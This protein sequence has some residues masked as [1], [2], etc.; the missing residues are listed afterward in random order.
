MK[1]APRRVLVVDDDAAHRTMLC[2]ILGDLDLAVDRAADGEEALHALASRPPDL[3]ILDMRMPVLDGLGTLR[4]MSERS[5]HVPTIILTAHADLDD[6]VQA[7]KL[8]ALDYLRKPIDIASLQSLL[9]QHLAVGADRG[10]DDLPDLPLGV[11]AQSPLMRAVLADLARVAAS[12]APLLL[13]GETGTG[14]DVLAGLAHRWSRQNAGPLVA[15]NVAALPESLVESELFGHSRG[16]FTGAER[17]RKGH[18][19][20]ADGGTLF[21]DEIGEMPLGVQ[22]KILRA[23]QDGKISRLGEATER[24]FNFR[25]VSAT[26]RDLEGAVAAGEFRQDLYYRIAVITIEVPPLRE[27]REDILPLARGFL[28]RE[29]GGHKR[30]SPSAEDLLLSYAW[31]GNI[32]ELSSAMLRAA[33]LAPGDVILPDNLPPALRSGPTESVGLG[34]ETGPDGSDLSLAQLEKRAIE[35]ALERSGGNR[36]EA[37][38]ALGISRRK[39]LYRLKQYREG[40]AD[41]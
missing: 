41:S 4:A 32:R 24:R 14:K 34:A 19:E 26:N 13:R 23:L 1:P 29:G 5:I 15:V 10:V 31:P 33:V 35:A 12:A 30:L 9:E 16:A 11:I 27:R 22:P 20:A 38:Q 8:G 18:F 2:E 25:L 6:A 40:T 28:E 3:M 36:T 7:M 17:E 37:A 39:L 21:L